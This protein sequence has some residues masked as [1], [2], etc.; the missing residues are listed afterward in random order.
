MAL[1]LPSRHLN[2]HLLHLVWIR[3]RV[4][5]SL[6]EFTSLSPPQDFVALAPDLR[7]PLSKARLRLL[8]DDARLYERN[9]ISQRSVQRAD[10]EHGK[11]EQEH[12]HHGRLGY[13]N[14]GAD[15]VVEQPA[16]VYNAREQRDD[17]ARVEE[18]RVC[19]W[20]LLEDFDAAL[21]NPAPD[22][23][24]DEGGEHDEEEGADVVA[25]DSHGEAGLGDG[26]PGLFVK[27]LDFDRAQS[28]KAQ[29][30]EAVHEGAIDEEEEV[31][32]NHEAQIG[33]GQVD[34]GRVEIGALP[35]S[36]RDDG[37]SQ[38]GRSAGIHGEAHRGRRVQG[39]RR[40]GDGVGLA[41]S[42]L[43]TRRR[44]SC[45]ASEDRESR[46]DG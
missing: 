26:E 35:K 19:R 2:I 17:K 4:A 45:R 21:A 43:E 33:L 24:G 34:H 32:E 36:R 12:N 30:L 7:S 40:V 29:A 27:L 6:G 20:L 13:S 16:I 42:M 14:D 28:T 41:D 39:R 44:E 5:L 18:A 31:D 23:T 25:E 11:L 46:E 9:D 10:G 1:G 22:F 8:L 38:R 3:Q 15:R 37:Y